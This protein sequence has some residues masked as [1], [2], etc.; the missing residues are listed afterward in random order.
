MER[1]MIRLFHIQD[2]DRPCYVIAE[3]YQLA[4]NKWKEQ[5]M[6]E[7]EIQDIEEVYEP[8]GVQFLAE[9][10]LDCILPD[11]LL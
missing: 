6:K 5:I 11:I 2:S 7:N 3:D 10:C 4:V 9:N 1:V 8:Q